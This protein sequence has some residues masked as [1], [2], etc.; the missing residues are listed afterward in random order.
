[1]PSI[2]KSEKN[3][4]YR[5][6]PIQ[7]KFKDDIVRVY[8]YN[9]KLCKYEY[10]MQFPNVIVMKPTKKLDFAKKALEAMGVQITPAMKGFVEESIQ[11]NWESVEHDLNHLY[12]ADDELDKDEN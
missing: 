1:M 9:E 7:Y 3:Q 8:Q 10:E 6:I 11:Q 12:D 5:R 2:K 4:L